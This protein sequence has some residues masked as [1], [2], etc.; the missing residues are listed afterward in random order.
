MTKYSEEIKLFILQN[1]KGIG[2]E[3]LKNLINNAFNT[4]F[5]TEQIKRYKANHKL[6]SGLTGHFVKGHVPQNKGKKMSEEIYKKC[7]ATMFKKGNV[8]GN[9][10]PIGSERAGKDGYIQIKVAEPNK[11]QQKNVYIYEQFYGIKIPK[12][13]KV[14]FLDQNKYNF[15]ISNLALVQNSEHLIMCSKNRF[16][17]NKEITKTFL[18]L[19]KLENQITRKAK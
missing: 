4:E 17:K 11:W 18:S 10:K 19:S 3:A 2:N 6:N 15:D 5:T 7:A 14:I 13:H 9:H 1:Y 12:G 8:P 16:S